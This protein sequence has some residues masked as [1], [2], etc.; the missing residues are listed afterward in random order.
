MLTEEEEQQALDA[1]DK[2][3]DDVLDLR[4]K[5]M[6]ETLSE[7]QADYIADSLNDRLRVYYK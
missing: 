6:D 3:I 2:F 5:L 1:L 7:E 4:D